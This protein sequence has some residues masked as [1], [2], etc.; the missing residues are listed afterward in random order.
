MLNVK[1][2]L[3]L[4]SDFDVFFSFIQI[5]RDYDEE[6][7]GFASGSEKE[8]GVTEERSLSPPILEAGDKDSDH[9]PVDMD[10]SD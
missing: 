7:K 8:R 4:S 6:E 10:M 5:K 9:Q 3:I 2:S 1:F